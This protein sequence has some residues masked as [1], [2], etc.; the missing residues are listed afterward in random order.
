MAKNIVIKVANKNVSKVMDKITDGA[1]PKWDI[2]D[3]QVKRIQEK[4]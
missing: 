2:M 1:Y 4:E 3:I